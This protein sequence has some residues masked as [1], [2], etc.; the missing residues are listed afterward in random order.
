MDG[1]EAV[2]VDEVEANGTGV[3]QCR[4]EGMRCE[5]GG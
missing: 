5:E 1:K 2:I 4:V 3:E